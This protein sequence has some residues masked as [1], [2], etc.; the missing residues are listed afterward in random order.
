M[1]AD[2]GPSV[3]L[4]HHCPKADGSSP[5][6]HSCLNGALDWSIRVDQADMAGVI[7][8]TSVKNRNGAPCRL[9]FKIRSQFISSDDDGDPI[10]APVCEEVDL[11]SLPSGGRLNGAKLAT[12]TIF[13]DM[14][15]SDGRVSVA[16]W[17]ERCIA[18]GAI[19]SA[20]NEKSRSDAFAR[21]KRDLRTAKLIALGGDGA[22][23]WAAR[24]GVASAGWATELPQF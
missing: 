5:R 18:P 11:R 14:A 16:A 12:L 8:C 24:E 2:R 1:I 15:G 17:R 10:T 9:G 6:G 19:S 20:K 3:T 7:R 4:I 22:G 23:E 13:D 21:A